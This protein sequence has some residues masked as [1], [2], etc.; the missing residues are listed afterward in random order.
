VARLKDGRIGRFGW[1]AQTASLE[2][3]VL[4]ACAVEL[5][6]EV[7]DHPQGGLPMRP[8][9]KPEGLDLTAEQC[10]SLTSYVRALA[11][12]TR[13][14]SDHPD[15]IAGERAFEAIGCASCHTPKLGDVEGIYSDLLVHD[16]GPDL[17]DVGQY[18]VFVPD[19]AEPEIEDE[20]QGPIAAGEAPPAQVVQETTVAVAEAPV[21]VGEAPVAVVDVNEVQFT[22]PQPAQVMMMGGGFGGMSGMAG[23]FG[24]APRPKDGPAGRQEWR[25]PPLW[26]LRDGAPYLHDGRADTL[27]EAIA[28][29]G[30]EATRVAQN[31]FEL[32]PK[33]RMQLQAF[34]KSLTAPAEELAAAA[35]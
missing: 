33:E 22:T 2:D 15:V 27:E 9:Y 10:A 24:V 6:L 35:K 4:T 5:G 32:S 18:G 3:F 1:K 21:A 13:V 11:A 28:L 17:G 30:G 14:N 29:H 23:P 12:P 34:L 25:T 31:Y 20:P 19:S 8:D 26:G 16:L 7:P